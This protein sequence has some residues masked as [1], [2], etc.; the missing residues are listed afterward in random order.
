[1]KVAHH[2]SRNS[3]AEDFLQLIQ[4]TYSLI[5]CGKDNFYGHP[6]EELVN[7]LNAVGTKVFITTQSGAI[8][9]KTDGERMKVGEFLF[10]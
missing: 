5:S 3:T 4:P 6:H 8:S 7:R 10:H 1:M 2:G 9:I